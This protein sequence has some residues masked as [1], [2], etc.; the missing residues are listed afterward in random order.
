MTLLNPMTISD[1]NSVKNLV[2]HI[3]KTHR[4]SRADQQTLMSF[5]LSKDM[6]SRE[7]NQLINSVFD[8]VRQGRIRVSD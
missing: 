2:D 8:A 4:L 7:E 1:D 6:I 5:L 3:F